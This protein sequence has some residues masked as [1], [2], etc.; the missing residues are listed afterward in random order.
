MQGLEKILIEPVGIETL[1]T[2]QENYN[3]EHFNRTSWNWNLVINSL[4]RE[5]TI[6]LIEPVGIETTSSYSYTYRVSRF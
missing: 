1:Q 2:Q 3:S 5:S 4:E 6:I